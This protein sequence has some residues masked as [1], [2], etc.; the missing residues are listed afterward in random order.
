LAQGGSGSGSVVPVPPGSGGVVGIADKNQFGAAVH[1]PQQR[2]V[3]KPEIIQ[4]CQFGL[5]TGETGNPFVDR[6]G[7]ISGYNVISLLAE[8]LDRKG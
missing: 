7:A 8:G 2:L 4:R 1:Q 3:I 5:N 6:K